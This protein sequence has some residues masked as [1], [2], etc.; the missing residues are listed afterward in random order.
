MRAES[1][2]DGRKRKRRHVQPGIFQ[3]ASPVEA[4]KDRRVDRFAFHS[5]SASSELRTAWASLRSAPPYEERKNKKGSG[6]PTDAYSTNR[7]LR[8]AARATLVRVTTHERFGRA[9]LSAFHCGTRGGDRTPPLNSSHALPGSGVIRCYLHLR[10]SQSSGRLPADRSS[11][12]PGVSA[13]SRPGVQLKAALAG[14]AL[15][16]S[17]GVTGDVPKLSEM[18]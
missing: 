17:F 15:A 12:R 1:C 16:P 8:G 13:R 4:A 10:L 11:C 6:T 14:T 2:R 7:T 9:R 5:T 3:I 18:I